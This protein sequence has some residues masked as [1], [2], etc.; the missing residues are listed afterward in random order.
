MGNINHRSQTIQ[1]KP[2][3]IQEIKTSNIRGSDNMLEAL[4]ASSAIIVAYHLGKHVARKEI[5]EST[6]E[7]TK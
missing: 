2:K 5:K 7:S 3:K 6:K 4:I 1:H